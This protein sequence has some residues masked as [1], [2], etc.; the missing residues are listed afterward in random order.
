MTGDELAYHE[1]YIQGWNEHD[2]GTVVDQFARG[3]TYDDPNLEEPLAGEEIGE[4][5]TEIA[6][7]F[8]DFHI[9]ERRLAETDGGIVHE[10][11]M[12]GTHS[13]TLDGLPPTGNTIALDGVDV[14]RI[15]SDGIISVRGYFDQ[16]TFAQ[17]LG[18][19]F[20]TIIGQVPALA[21]GA[22]TERL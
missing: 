15:D 4:Y 22:V 11:T 5:V 16:K 17:Q 9:E 13:G 14:V 10:W 19:T 3:G 6:S 7:G 1:R 2:P 21:V 20:P 8:P 12:H 18:L